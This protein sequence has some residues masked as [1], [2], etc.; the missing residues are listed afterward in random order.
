MIAREHVKVLSVG[1]GRA[2]VQ[3]VKPDDPSKCESCPS[4]GGCGAGS[5]PEGRMPALDVTGLGDV[6][7]GDELLIDLELASP[8]AAA[9]LLLIFP[10]VAAFGAGF[11]AFHFTQSGLAGLGAGILGAAAAYG[12][13][14]L[15]GPSGPAN[16]KIVRKP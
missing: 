10:M 5:G 4:S 14:Y 2:R 7:E 8:A 16:A 15:V 6:S 13:V 9:V 3:I 1:A 12:L 11:L